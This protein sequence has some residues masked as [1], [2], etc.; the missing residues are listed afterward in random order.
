MV[1]FAVMNAPDFPFK[2]IIW[3]WNGTLLDDKWLCIESINQVLGKRS[4]PPIDE[5]TY[6]RIFGFPV[7]DYYLKAGFDFTDEPYEKPALEFIERYDER[8][9][10]CL[11]QPGARE[12]IRHLHQM[13]C[14]QYLLSASET[15]VLTEMI[16]LKGIDHYFL[17]VKGL[18]NHYAHGKADLGIELLAEINPEPG[19]VLMIGDTCHDEEVARIMGIPCILY[20]GGH[21]T[22]ERL[23]SCTSR[24]INGLEELIRVA[25]GLNPL[26][27]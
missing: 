7:R 3:D 13:G 2:H 25:S 19:T 10:E 27:G 4:L 5:M 1:F 9:H 24:I 12:V 18:D 14:F 23:T 22:A 11:L 21:F 6:D 15:G 26:H 8:K 16:R 20:A 17:K